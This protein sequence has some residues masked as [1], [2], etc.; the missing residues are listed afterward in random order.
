MQLQAP[1]STQ[2]NHPWAALEV[3][4]SNPVLFVGRKKFKKGFTFD[5]YFNFL[6]FQNSGKMQ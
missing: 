6:T 1:L 5:F 2:S 4:F 3:N